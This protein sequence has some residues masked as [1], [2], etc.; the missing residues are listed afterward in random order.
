MT[1]EGTYTIVPW[2]ALWRPLQIL[3]LRQIRGGSAALRSSAY[4]SAPIRRTSR[5]TDQMGPW[6]PPHAWMTSF[7]LG[8][9][10]GLNLHLEA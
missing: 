9:G 2:E 1:A 6:L 4:L 3:G 8:L 7:G 5:Q 10:L